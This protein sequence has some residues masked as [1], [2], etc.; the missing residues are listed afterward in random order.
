MDVCVPSV[1][2][3]L[4]NELVHLVFTGMVCALFYWS[5]RQVMGTLL[6]FA[7]AMFLDADHLVDYF[8]Y[9][10]RFS[11]NVNIKEFISGAYFKRW[12]KFVCPLHA[13]ELVIIALIIWQIYSNIIAL[14][15]AIGI[16]T[17]LVID[18][19]T[20]TVNRVAYFFS[21]RAY[22]YFHKPAIAPQR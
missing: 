2:K 16:T 20:N 6:V 21:F 17:H 12:Q 5:F 9:A 15:L 11:A 3:T 10:I 8:L 1:T 19:C 14:A 7:S 18:Y 22:H 13:W 4:R